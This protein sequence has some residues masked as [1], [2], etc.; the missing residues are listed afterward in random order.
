MKTK[1][2]LILSLIGFMMSCSKTVVVSDGVTT[3]KIKIKGNV[4]VVSD[5]NNN[6]YS[7]FESVKGTKYNINNK[8][9]TVSMK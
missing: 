3:K 5:S 4:A 9:Y 1:G 8:N 2:L 6:T 7:K